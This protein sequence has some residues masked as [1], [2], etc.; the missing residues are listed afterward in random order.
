[1]V[2]LDLDGSLEFSSST[3]LGGGGGVALELLAIIALLW[4]FVRRTMCLE[5]FQILW[6]CC[7]V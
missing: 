5:V 1:M 6:A 7:V 3:H 2:D 4:S